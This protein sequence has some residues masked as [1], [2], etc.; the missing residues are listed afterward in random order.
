MTGRRKQGERGVGGFTLIEVMIALAI[1]AGMLTVLLRGAAGNVA[2]TQRSRMMTAATELAR[3]KMYDIEED[4]LHNGFQPDLQEDEGDFEEEGW[5]QISWKSEIEK[6]ELPNA[7]ALGGFGEDGEDSEGGG[8]SGGAGGLGGGGLG[9]AIIGS[10]F[11]MVKNMMEEALRRVRITITYKVA[12]FTEEFTV[13][14]YFTDPAAIG[15]VNSLAAGGAADTSGSDDTS[16]SG[17]SSGRS[18]SDTKESGTTK[19]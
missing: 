3:G 16:S 4:L 18:N 14:C 9:G 5:P 8:A 10:Q 7:E 15:R 6:V 11:E 2:A 1:L 13:D 17:S 19:R 12:G